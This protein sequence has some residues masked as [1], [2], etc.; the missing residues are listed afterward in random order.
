MQF[1]ALQIDEFLSWLHQNSNELQEVE[2]TA[3]KMPP[4]LTLPLGEM[5]EFRLVIEVA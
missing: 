1:N 4:S 5:V 2:S 3:V